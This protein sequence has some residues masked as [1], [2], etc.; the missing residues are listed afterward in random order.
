[1]VVKQNINNEISQDLPII[2]LSVKLSKGFILFFFVARL[3]E[4]ILNS[5]ETRTWSENY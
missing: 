2:Q 5:A 4:G 3:H 1:M